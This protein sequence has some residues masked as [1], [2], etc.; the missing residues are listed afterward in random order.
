MNWQSNWKTDSFPSQTKTVIPSLSKLLFTMKHIMTFIRL[1]LQWI[2][3]VGNIQ[4]L[5][6]SWPDSL[7]FFKIVWV[8]VR[9]CVYTSRFWPKCSLWTFFQA[10]YVL[11]LHFTIIQ[12][13]YISDFFIRSQK[14]SLDVSMSRYFSVF[15]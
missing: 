8:C 10:T 12:P 1:Q 15:I 7:F 6:H 13:I 5:D 9:V 11:Q 3:I 14:V 4:L 2:N